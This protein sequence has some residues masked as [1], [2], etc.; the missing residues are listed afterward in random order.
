MV[1]PC[2]GVYASKVVLNDVCYPAVTNI[3][4]RPTI[5]TGEFHS[6]TCILGFSGDLYGQQVRVTLLSYLRQERKFQDLDALRAAMTA[7][8]AAAK[9]VLLAYEQAFEAAGESSLL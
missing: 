1:R 2:A 6:E 8:A 3:G 4:V 7:D 9:E 5:G